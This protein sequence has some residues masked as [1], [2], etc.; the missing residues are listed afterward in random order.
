[1]AE[2]APTKAEHRRFD[3][4]TREVGCICCRMK[5]GRYLPAQANHLLNGCRIGHSNVTPECPWHHMGECFVGTDA[6]AMRKAFGPSRKLHKKAF[7]K[8]FG[9]DAEL[10]SL[11][12]KYVAAFEAQTIGG[13]NHEV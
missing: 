8:Q 3:I 5:F 4:I 11:T 13:G 9:S 6:R 1:M 7:A 10:L 2:K 12:N